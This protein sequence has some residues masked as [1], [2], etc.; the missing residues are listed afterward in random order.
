[1]RRVLILIPCSGSK[2][3]GGIT[4]YSTKSSILN[5]LTGS[6]RENLLGLRRKLFEYFS[7]PFGQDVGYPNDG[8]TKYMEAYKRY[9]GNIY[10]QIYFSSWEKI[11]E[12]QNLDLVIVSALYGLLRYDEPIQDYNVMMSGEMGKIG[13]Q[14]LKTWWRNNGLCAILKNYING[15]NISEVHNVLSNDYNEAL[16]GCFIDMGARYSYHDYS[17][18]KS[19]SNAHRGRWVNDFIRNF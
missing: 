10:C 18:Y 19:G 7:I 13:H 5:Y 3:S 9:A 15:N 11:G 6:S 12:T 17:E 8:T 4:E 1:M 14:T 16:R 2:K